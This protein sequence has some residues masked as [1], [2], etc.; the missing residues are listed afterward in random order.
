MTP[1]HKVRFLEPYTHVSPAGWVATFL[2]DT[3]LDVAIM[4]DKAT[5]VVLKFIPQNAVIEM[6]KFTLTLT[7][8]Q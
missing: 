7:P 6:P 8:I 1:T 2:K 4:E 3:E 5:T